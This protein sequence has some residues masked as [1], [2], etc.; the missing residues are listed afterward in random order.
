MNAILNNEDT[1]H[2]DMA[3]CLHN[4]KDEFYALFNT[5]ACNLTVNWPCYMPLVSRKPCLNHFQSFEPDF[6]GVCKI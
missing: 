2:I 3:F 5:T 4:F 1:E 6:P